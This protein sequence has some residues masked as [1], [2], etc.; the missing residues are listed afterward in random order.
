MRAV[1]AVRTAHTGGA[2]PT[3]R[4]HPIHLHGPAATGDKTRCV[5]TA[6]LEEYT[7]DWAVIT[8]GVVGQSLTWG[9]IGNVGQIL[10]SGGLAHEVGCTL[11]IASGF[12]LP[13]A[14]CCPCPFHGHGQRFWA[15]F[16]AMTPM[17]PQSLASLQKKHRPC[18]AVHA[19]TSHAEPAAAP[20]PGNAFPILVTTKG[21]VMGAA[22]RVNEGGGRVVAFV[23]ERFSHSS[24]GADSLKVGRQAWQALFSSQLWARSSAQGR[25]SPPHV[26]PAGRPMPGRPMMG[27]CPI[28]SSK[29][30]FLRSHYRQASPRPRK[31]AAT[32]LCPSPPRTLPP[33]VGC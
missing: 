7:S 12:S 19:L 20:P 4:H 25:P 15:A 23:E 10:L 13:P 3:P 24:L 31:T 22:A 32:I 14:S 5:A 26:V 2:C 27:G 9:P 8:S 16:F 29:A 17:T 18:L 6:A 21:H 11:R 1:C 28:D 33:S 30:V